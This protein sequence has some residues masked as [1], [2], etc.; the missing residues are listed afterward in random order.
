MTLSSR[1]ADA[2][3][4]AATLHAKQ[5]RKLSGSPYVGH[6]LAVAGIVLQFGGDEDE[7]IGAL[8]HDA[9]EDQGGEAAADDIRRRFGD[10]VADL[11]I[12]CSDTMVTP[13]PPWRE[14]KE[15]HVAHMRQ[16]DES[17]RLIVAADK[18]DN[19]RSILADYRLHGEALWQHFRG[20]RDGTLWY[21]RAMIE[22][23]GRAGRAGRIITEVEKV[24]EQLEQLAGK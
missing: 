14:R 23:L 9:A 11:A 8:L 15:A 13:K 2:L 16:A 17:V 12:A 5:Q 3:V 20:R 24:V 7:A 6:L 18:L 22:A 21:Y 4:Y 1:F 10:R 19:A